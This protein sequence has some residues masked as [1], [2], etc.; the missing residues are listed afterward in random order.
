MH[1]GQ[2]HTEAADDALLDAYSQAVVSAV[3]RVLPC[4]VSLRVQQRRARGPSGMFGQGSGLVVAPD[5]Y[6][7][8]NSHVVQ[9]AQHVLASFSSG[10]EAEGRVVGDDPATDLALVRVHGDTPAH[11][12]LLTGGKPRPGQLAIAIGN[13]LGFDA[14]VSTGVVSALGRSLT[15]PKGQLI[16]DVIQHTAPLNPGNSGGPLVTSSG[17]VLGIN[18]A[19]AG[20]SQG[21]GFAIPVETAAWVVGELLARGRVRRAYLGIAVQTR[22]L[23]GQRAARSG[24]A[25]HTCVE[26]MS[27]GEDTPAARAGLEVS[28]ILLSLNGTALAHAGGLHRALRHVAPGQQVHLQILRG[29]ERRT[30]ELVPSEAQE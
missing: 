16:D 7:L 3:D 22:P 13:P 1:D 24:Q 21:I 17:R 9:R 4:V 20:R 6:I 30:L 2:A 27:V 12:Q 14:T 19:M 5:G 18:S 28:D 10:V 29:G 26:V 11:A 23:S 25:Q 8:T 15:G